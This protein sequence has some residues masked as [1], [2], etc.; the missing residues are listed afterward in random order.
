MKTLD[1]FSSLIGFVVALTVSCMAGA[2]ALRFYEAHGHI[3]VEW[4]VGSANAV[5]MGAAISTYFLLR[6]GDLARKDT[7]ERMAARGRK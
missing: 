4:A 6:A 7:E 3:P 5:L 2:L 1:F